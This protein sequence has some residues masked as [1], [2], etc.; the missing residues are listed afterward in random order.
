MKCSAKFKVALLATCNTLFWVS[1]TVSSV[2][3]TQASI[4]VEVLV[5]LLWFAACFTWGTI[6]WLVKHCI[7]P[8][9]KLTHDIEQMSHTGDF[10]YISTGY[11]KEYEALVV[12]V[13]KVVTL[14]KEA[15]M[16]G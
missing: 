3:M 1:V 9:S 10:S 15:K 11:S 5:V 8:I 13:Q 4:S 2:V 6:Y 14:A 7:K 16:N 12:A